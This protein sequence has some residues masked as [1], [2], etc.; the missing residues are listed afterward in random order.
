MPAV[1]QSTS[2][3]SVCHASPVICPLTHANAA[4]ALLTDT[5]GCCAGEPQGS[6]PW[7]GPL[8]PDRGPAGGPAGCSCGG[9]CRQVQA[10]PALG[11]Y[12]A[13]AQPTLLTAQISPEDHSRS[14]AVV[15]SREG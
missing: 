12:V 10:S 14:V 15:Q 5:Q 11:P 13:A 9:S 6:A 2:L 3:K 8:P 4:A 1:Y 7:C